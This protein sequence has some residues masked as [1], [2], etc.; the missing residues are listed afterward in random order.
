MALSTC[1]RHGAGIRTIVKKNMK[2]PTK[3]WNR[4]ARRSAVHQTVIDAERHAKEEEEDQR[5]HIVT[6][7]F[8]T[9]MTHLRGGLPEE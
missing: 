8:S 9:T 7:F 1:V 6:K 2:S 4:S 5:C 3:K